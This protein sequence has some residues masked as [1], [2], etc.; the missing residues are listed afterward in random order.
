MPHIVIEHSNNIS[1]TQELLRIASQTL[2]QSKLFATKEEIKAR[3]YRNAHFL[4]GERQDEAYIVVTVALL[5]GR[6][7]E[8]RHALG[9]ALQENLAVLAYDLPVQLCIEIKEIQRELYFKSCCA[10]R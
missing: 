9:Q 1:N 2:I 4:V 3:A 5:T 10:S 6:T 7:H 8:Q